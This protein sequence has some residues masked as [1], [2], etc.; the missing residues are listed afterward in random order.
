[1]I[2][3]SIRIIVYSSVK[4]VVVCSSIYNDQNEQIVKV[5]LHSK[6]KERNFVEKMYIYTQLQYYGVKI[7]S[8]LCESDNFAQQ[9]D[10]NITGTHLEYLGS[11][12]NFAY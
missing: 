1:M 7:V 2:L 9:L 10:N 6:F 5:L 4:N 12:K 11:V 8:S 3:A